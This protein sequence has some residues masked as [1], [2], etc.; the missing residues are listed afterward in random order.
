M[1]IS[2][3]LIACAAGFAA[4]VLSTGCDSTPDRHPRTT[5]T[6][7]LSADQVAPDV[8][9]GVVSAVQIILPPG[10]GGYAWEISSNNTRVLEQ[11]GPLK[12]GPAS[13]PT[14]SVSFYSLKPGRSVL[15]FV[16]VRP[17]EAEAVPAAKCEVTVR[18]SD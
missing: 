7:V 2:L 8:A 15:R 9:L 12:A 13:A 17:G 14:T 4:V 1:K 11:M 18:V 10:P 16:L 3:P 6:V 5:R